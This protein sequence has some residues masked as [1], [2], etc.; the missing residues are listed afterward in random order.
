M[1]FIT[2]LPDKTEGNYIEHVEGN[3]AVKAEGI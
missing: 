1:C 3:N 2:D